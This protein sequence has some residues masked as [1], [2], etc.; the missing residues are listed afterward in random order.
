M[1][2]QTKKII[3]KN[4]K[5]VGFI[6]IFPKFR[7]ITLVFMCFFLRWL[8]WYFTVFHY[9]VSYC[10]HCFFPP[11]SFRNYLFYKLSN[12]ISFL[13]SQPFPPFQSL[14]FVSPFLSLFTHP[15]HSCSPSLPPSS[16]SPQSTY[17]PLAL[18]YLSTS[19][20]SHPPFTSLPLSLPPSSSRPFFPLHPSLVPHHSSL[21]SQSLLPLSAPSSP[22]L[23]LP[24][25]NPRLNNYTSACCGHQVYRYGR[26]LCSGLRVFC[27]T[28]MYWLHSFFFQVKFLCYR[29]NFY[30]VSNP[31][32]F[33]Y[34]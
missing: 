30:W 22:H 27:R 6:N 11:L 25:P 7:C 4:S 28:R 20:M 14:N 18:L 17:F 2:M 10:R 31:Y 12:F 33:S 23:S 26:C 1:V 8:L 29:F 34:H 13:L 32:E 9:F 3:I 16:P 15:S 21:P 24:H 19:L 5:K